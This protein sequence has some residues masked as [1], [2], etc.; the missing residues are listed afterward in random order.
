[1][2]LVAHPDVAKVAFTGSEA[3]GR[4]INESAAA[5]FKHVALEL[6]G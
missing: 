6:G 5:G 1:V 4:R 2:P 3:G